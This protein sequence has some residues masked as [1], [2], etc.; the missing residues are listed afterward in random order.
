MSKFII[1]SVVAGLVTLALLALVG[2]ICYIAVVNTPNFIVQHSLAIFQGIGTAF[3]AFIAGA[4]L[5]RIK[6]ARRVLHKLT[7]KCLF[8]DGPPNDPFTQHI[9]NLFKHYH[10]ND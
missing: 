6:V 5:R 10:D 2:G 3:G 4:L 7:C 8:H 9:M 1:E